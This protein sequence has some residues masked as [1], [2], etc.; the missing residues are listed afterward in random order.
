MG[1]S[2]NKVIILGNLTRD[3]EV[4]HTQSNTAVA[5]FAVATNEAWKNK[6]TGEW[7]ESAEFHR[8][9][10]WRHLA[11]RAE[12]SLRKGTR[13]YVEGKLETRK[14]EKD[15][16]TNYTTEIIARD[17]VVLSKDEDAPQQPAPAQAPADDDDLPF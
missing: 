9:V 2:V 11:E 16:H 14:W 3:P 4:K 5:N 1:K 17:I 6:Q 8:V 12:K 7:E 15:G 13:V 10:A